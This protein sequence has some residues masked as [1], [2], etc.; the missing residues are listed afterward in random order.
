ML[1]Q[2]IIEQGL[3]EIQELKKSFREAQNM[4]ILPI[5]FFSSSI[6]VINRLK[7]K[8]YEIE[9]LQLHVVQEKPL[10]K[11]ENGRENEDNTIDKR[12]A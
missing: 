9:A 1:H 2:K 6:D 4:E 12:F 3:K 7:A 8:I 10:E 11:Q 5:S